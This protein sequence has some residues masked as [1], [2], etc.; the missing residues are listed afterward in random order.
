MPRS[1]RSTFDP[2]VP[3]VRFASHAA[4]AAVR[5]A[6]LPAL[7]A[8]ALGAGSAVAGPVQTV[9][10][11]AMENE[12]FI[13]PGNPF[14]AGGNQQILN[15]PNAPFLN[16]LL[17]GTATAI[18]NGAPVSISSQTAYASNYGAVQPNASGTVHPSEPN[19]IWSEAGTNFGVKNDNE[20]F[21]SSG[22][23]NQNTGAHLSALLQ[24]YGRTWKSYQEDIDLAT[25][26]NG[27]L[28]NSVLPQSQWTV[29]LKNANNGNGTGANAAPGY[30]N[31]YNGSH[32]YDYGAKHNPMVFFSD[33]NG[34]NNS[35]PSNPL[36]QHYA[37]LQQLQTDLADNTVAQYNWITPDQFNDM[38][39]ALNGTYKGLTSAGD[40]R[41][42]QGDDFLAMIVPQI[43]A[44]QAYQNDGAIIL[45][46]DETEPAGGIPGENADDA[47]HKIAEIVISPDAHPNVNGLPYTN[48]IAYTH[49]SDLRTLQEIFHVGLSDPG[50]GPWLRDAAN[51]TDLS[52]LFAAGAIP[53]VIP[54]PGT[55]LMFGLGLAALPLVWRR[56]S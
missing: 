56:R 13:Q 28:T 48:T 1:T 15:N 14:P 30:T 40:K 38:H 25:D 47:S 50:S 16:S 49:S 17:N 26:A 18:I 35:T 33:T 3:F 29:P 20:P 55:L 37:P 41:I 52:D 8:S 24:Q 44:S 39:T 32:Q 12:N 53:S 27:K 54:E 31:P 22:G 43:M 42:R 5:R 21:A 9:F 46:W 7:V 11:I 4:P 45:W 2:F 23:T 51:A 19:Y 6:V 36:A 10:V 34:G